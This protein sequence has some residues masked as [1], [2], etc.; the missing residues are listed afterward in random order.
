MWSL[1]CRS[2]Q[3][4]CCGG[5]TKTARKSKQTANSSISL[6]SP[7]ET[8]QAILQPVFDVVI[9]AVLYKSVTPSLNSLQ[10]FSLCIEQVRRHLNSSGD[11]R[12]FDVLDP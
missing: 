10:S 5:G 8:E 7:I 6:Q 4:S 1:L 2:Y 11:L 12:I 9:F 3:A